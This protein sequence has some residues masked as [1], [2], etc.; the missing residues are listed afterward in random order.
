[1]VLECHQP[2]EKNRMQS[3]NDFIVFETMAVGS[4]AFGGQLAA[5]GTARADIQKNRK[6]GR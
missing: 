4:F 3:L 2:E 1:M 6:T 5:Y